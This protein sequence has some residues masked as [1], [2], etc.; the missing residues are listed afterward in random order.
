MGKGL[1]ELGFFLGHKYVGSPVG[2]GTQKDFSATWNQAHVW[3]Q[4]FRVKLGPIIVSKKPPFYHRGQNPTNAAGSSSVANTWLQ[5]ERQSGSVAPCLK[6]CFG[7]FT[8]SY[9]CTF[10]LCTEEETVAIK[11]IINEHT[12]QNLLW[13]MFFQ[14]HWTQGHLAFFTRT[15]SSL[16]HLQE[17]REPLG[18]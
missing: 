10:F 5:Q 11:I 3:I 12:G 16:H 13:V 4:S 8:Y 9:K 18:G 6:N 2:M 17:S 14:L 7:A 15:L 1:R